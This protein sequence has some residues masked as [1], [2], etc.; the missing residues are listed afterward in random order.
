MAIIHRPIAST[1]KDQVYQILKEEIC[2][3]VYAPGQWLQEKELAGRLSVSRSPIREA[4]RQ[5]AGDGLVV[6]I[7]NK[8]V[9]VKEFALR[10]IDEVF[11]L[12][13][14]MES[15]AILRSDKNLTPEYKEEL[16]RYVDELTRMHNEGRLKRYIELDT[17][18][19]N[20]FITLSGNRLLEESYRKV[21]TMIQQFR[22]YS[23][24]GQQRFDESVEEHR[25]IVHCILTG[26]L[27]EAN[28]A[29]QHHL[30]LAK[31]KILEY[32]ENKSRQ[33]ENKK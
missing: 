31:E 10:D 30:E 14:M 24:I 23:L 19:H 20:L 22:I 25:E 32:L 7:P 28:R 29:N 27:E 13:L 21:H 17:Q 33:A 18:L 11:D 16:L 12:R 2:S 6:D 4:L 5:L 26:A 3:G 9:F 1:I 8:G 15:Y